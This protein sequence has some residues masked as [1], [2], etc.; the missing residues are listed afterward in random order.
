MLGIFVQVTGLYETFDT[1]FHVGMGGTLQGVIPGV[2]RSFYMIHNF[3]NNMLEN[4][5]LQ[6]PDHYTGGGRWNNTKSETSTSMLMSK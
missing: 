4:Y 2:D 6:G 3:V 1:N 5:Q